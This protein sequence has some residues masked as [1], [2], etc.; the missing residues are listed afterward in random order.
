[1]EN[2]KKDN[3]KDSET[4]TVTEKRNK[5]RGYNE[6]RKT[7]KEESKLFSIGLDISNWVV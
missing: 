2:D 6:N 7:N 5:G 1:V 4:Q 3:S